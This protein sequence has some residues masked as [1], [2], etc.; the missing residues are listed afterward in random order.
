MSFDND[1]LETIPL[2]D[3]YVYRDNGENIRLGFSN[4]VRFG[5]YSLNAGVL[6]LTSKGAAELSIEVFKE[7][8]VYYLNYNENTPVVLKDVALATLKFDNK[9]SFKSLCSFKFYGE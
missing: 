2:K 4:S 8:N 5:H 1:V 3:Y 6:S 7:K 9:E